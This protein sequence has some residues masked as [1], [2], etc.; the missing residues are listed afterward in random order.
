[1]RAIVGLFALAALVLGGGLLLAGPGAGWGFWDFGRSFEIYRWFAAPKEIV[2]PVALPPALTAGLISLLG[3]LAFLFRG[4]RALGAFALIAALTAAAGSY[5]PIK[6]RALAEAYPFI[7]DITTDFE[8]PPEI[9]AAADLPRKN[10]ADYVG[11]EQVGDTGK[12]VAQSQLEAFPDITPI[13]IDADVQAATERA[14]AAIS[15]LGMEVLA[16]GPVSEESGSGWRIEAVYTSQWFRFKDDFIVRI[17][18]DTDGKT[19]LDVRSKSR[20][21]GSDLGANGERIRAFR[22]LMIAGQA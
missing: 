4:P 14:R 2:G 20:V 11:D 8:N 22:D 7:H 5:V 12:T 19:R 3:G 21:G 6:M 9:V 18:N 13:L 16:E 10:P 17:K 15:A 1:M